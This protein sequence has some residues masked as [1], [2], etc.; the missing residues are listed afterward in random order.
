M[1]IMKKSMAAI[2]A[3]AM[4]FTCVGGMVPAKAEETEVSLVEGVRF[5]YGGSNT[6]MMQYNAINATPAESDTWN[7]IQGGNGFG[8]IYKYSIDDIDRLE[9]ATL[10]VYITNSNAAMGAYVWNDDMPENTKDEAVAIKAD[11]EI[12]GNG[13]SIL[14]GSAN[15]STTAVTA[16]DGSTNIYNAKIS[17]DTEK[18]KNAADENGTVSILVSSNPLNYSSSKRHLVYDG[19]HRPSLSVSLETA[20]AGLTATTSTAE[21]AKGDDGTVATGFITTING[22]DTLENIQW[23]VTASD[24]TVGKSEVYEIGATVETELKLGIIIDGLDD[25]H[26]TAKAVINGT[27][28]EAE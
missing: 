19:P 25:A 8:A 12:W 9:A 15:S 7:E 20:P 11:Y 16:S 1:K 27:I 3:L 10:D 21:V 4:T 5:R 28:V 17:L 14:L 24:D 23:T 26:A 2:A 13:S 6:Y 22:S 18:L